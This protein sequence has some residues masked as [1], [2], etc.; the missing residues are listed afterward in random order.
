MRFGTFER[1]RVGR[2]TGSAYPGFLGRTDGRGRSV[3]RVVVGS[4]GRDTDCGTASGMLSERLEGDK[5]ME[6][7]GSLTTGGPTLVHRGGLGV[8]RTGKIDGL[9]LARREGG[10]GSERRVCP[11][12]IDLAVPEGNA[13]AV[14][15]VE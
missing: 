13:D 7:E 10:E 14:G 15:V 11:C 3:R 8:G 6:R 1:V 12:E 9:S 2:C 5:G 4:V